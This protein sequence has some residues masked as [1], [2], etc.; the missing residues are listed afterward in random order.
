MAQFDVIKDGFAE[1]ILRQADQPRGLLDLYSRLPNELRKLGWDSFR[2]QCIYLN[3]HGEMTFSDRG[4]QSTD[5]T[6][7]QPS[8]F[9]GRTLRELRRDP[10]QFLEDIGKDFYHHLTDH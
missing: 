4:A 7:P 2:I 10:I 9:P 3:H 1:E 5:T 6:A 8:L